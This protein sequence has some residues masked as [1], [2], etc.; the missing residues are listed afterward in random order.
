LPLFGARFDH[1]ADWASANSRFIWHGNELHIWFTSQDNG[2]QV[3]RFTNGVGTGVTNLDKG[4]GCSSAGGSF[5]ALLALGLLPLLRRSRLKR[6][7]AG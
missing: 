1:T 7:G 2:F 4:G 3:V 5:G 6:S